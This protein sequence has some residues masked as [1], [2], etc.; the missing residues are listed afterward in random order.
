M[1]KFKVVASKVG[2]TEVAGRSAYHL[3]NEA[4]S[5]I[6]AEIIEIAADSDEEYLE[7]AKDTDAIISGRKLN[8]AVI[9]GLNK[10]KVISLG[11]VGT[12]GVDVEA[13]TEKGIAVTNVPDTF[14]EEVADHT[15]AVSYTHLTL[16]T[17]DLV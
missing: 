10:C 2:N 16:P 9:E 3:E 6:G 17:S 8:R 13:A 11:S 4:L 1:A 15:I 7:K 5:G 14:I 12:D